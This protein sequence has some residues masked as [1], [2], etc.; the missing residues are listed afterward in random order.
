MTRLPSAQMYDIRG[1]RRSRLPNP[2]RNPSGP[3]MGRR[4]TRVG[5]QRQ[6]PRADVSRARPGGAGQPARPRADRPL[7]LK[8]QIADVDR[9]HH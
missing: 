5:R 9:S 2:R 3:T 8:D 1:R 4:Q 7:A 6:A